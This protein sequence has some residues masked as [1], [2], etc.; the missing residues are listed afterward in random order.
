MN[1]LNW[2]AKNYLSDTGVGIAPEELPFC[3]RPLLEGR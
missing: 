3:I 2:L 1:F